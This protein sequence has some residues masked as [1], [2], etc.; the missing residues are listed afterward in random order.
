MTEEVGTLR[1]DGESFEFQFADMGL[2]IRGAYAEWVL[3][4][5]GEVIAKTAELSSKG[6]IDALETMVGFGEASEIDLDIAKHDANTRFEAIPQ[7]LVHMG[8]LDY[9]WIAPEG[10]EDNDPLGGMLKRI[11]ILSKTRNGSFLKN[12]DGVDTT[13][14]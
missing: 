9:H 7:C 5:A 1:E 2:R 6:D 8:S 13:N 14:S 4:A 3:Q 11:V 12:I 10:R